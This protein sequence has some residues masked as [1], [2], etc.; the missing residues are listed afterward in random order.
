V[1]DLKR[2][3]PCSSGWNLAARAERSGWS[4]LKAGVLVLGSVWTIR[5]GWSDVL[6]QTELEA[7]VFAQAAGHVLLRLASVLAAL[8]LILG[9]IDYALRCRKFEAMLRTTP[10]EQREDQRVMEGDPAARAQRRRVVRSWRGDVPELLAGADL[11][12]CSQGGLTLVLSGGPPPRRV[13]V[14]TVAHGNVGL[15]IRRSAEASQIPQ[16]HAA[17]LARR[18]AYRPALGSPLAAELMAELT[19]IWPAGATK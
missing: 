9:L 8:L 10:Q 11:L 14:R 7:P 4:I 17:N 2:L 6:R 16:I 15:R 12:L 3:W 18:L 13:A 5:A 1:P 19:A